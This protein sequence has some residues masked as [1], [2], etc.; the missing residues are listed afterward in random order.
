MSKWIE[1]K[2]NADAVAIASRYKISGIFAEVLARRGFSSYKELDGYL[3]DDMGPVYDAS[4]MHGMTE[5]VDILLSKIKEGKAIRIVGD[6]DADGVMSTYILYRGIEHLGGKPTYR[7]PLREKDGYGIRDYMV[8]E[9]YD[10]GIDTIITCDNG[11]SAYDAIKYAKDLGMTVILTDHHEVPVIEGEE[12]IPPAD[13]VVDPKQKAC[14]YE[15]K[16]LCGAG[17]AYKLISLAYERSGI[18]P[19]SD[20]LVVF[21]A[22][23]TVC[24]VVP[25]FGENRN[26][27]K[28]GLAKINDTKCLGLDSLIELMAFKK[29]ISSYDLGF[30]IGPCINA[31]GRMGDAA[32]ALRLL[33][34]NDIDKAK[35]QAAQLADKNEERKDITLTSSRLAED[36]A[37]ASDDLPDVIIAYL[38]ECPESVA[39][40][41]AGRIRERYYRPAYVIT[42]TG[43]KLK[44]SGRSIPGYHMQRALLS[45]RDELIEFGGHALAAGFS[46]EKIKLDIVKSRL[47]AE[48]D[49]N[50]ED[51]E[52]KIYFEKVISFSEIDRTAAE[53]LGFIEPLGQGN[54][55]PLFAIRD[56]VLTKVRMVGREENIAQLSFA[57]DGKYYK[58]VDFA[59]D[60]GIGQT[61]CDKYGS[62]VWEKYKGGEYFE[63]KVDLLVSVKYDADYNRIEFF[64][65][66]SR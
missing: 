5:A 15:Y 8:R 21:A 37:E 59:G 17:I 25:L 10:E 47:T 50:P 42:G 63:A 12:V 39:G 57:E 18:P 34:E 58:G 49:I 44:G 28:Q 60:E 52:E 13:E 33:L 24:D 41:V 20:T 11:I 29:K 4:H 30:R 61:I 3:F 55:E 45:I 32:D 53:Q 56:A 40:I 54:E 43:D 65:K 31:A 46:L 66:D 62:H 2:P 7:L 14:G 22:I 51:L 35:E 9:A 27:V 19:E 16:E 6:Y 48:C 1:K 26:I 36:M 23:A 38:P 64:V